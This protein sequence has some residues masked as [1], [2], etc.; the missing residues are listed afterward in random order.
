VDGTR[1]AE[2]RDR[3][4]SEPS[5]AARATKHL[6]LVQILERELADGL[7]KRAQYLRY[8]QRA[9]FSGPNPKPVAQPVNQPE[10]APLGQPDIPRYVSPNACT[11]SGH[12]RRKYSLNP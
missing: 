7:K 2:Q 9:G 11:Y 3:P 4:Y 12:L 8:H 5:D 10:Q 1:D 6:G